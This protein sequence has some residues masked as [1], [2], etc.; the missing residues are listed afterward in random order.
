MPINKTLDEWWPRRW[1]FRYQRWI[2]RRIPPAREVA[3]GQRNLF[4]FLSSPGL[5]RLLLAVL[6]W[7][8]ATNYQNNL[9]MALCFL[10]LSVLL[11]AIHLTFANLNGL[12]VRFVSAEP[13]F[14]GEQ[15]QCRFELVAT[16]SRQQ[17]SLDW[18]GSPA[19][20][21]SLQAGVPAY[22][23]VPCT[24][25][26]RGVFQ[27]GRVRLQSDF[28]L[29]LIR[30][31]TWLD[32]C[33][34]V[35]VYPA[36]VQADFRDYA[37]GEGDDSGRM[38]AGTEDYFALRSYQPGDPLSRVAWK[39]FAAGRGVFVQEYVDYRGA[40]IWLDYAVMPHADPEMRLSKLCFCVLQL[41]ESGRLFGVSLPQQRFAPAA[42]HEHVQRVLRA[43]AVC[44]V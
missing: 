13:V 1:Q 37:Q 22:V 40:D 30:C 32:L 31:W 34:E 4:I 2:D 42:G 20:R 28:P 23:D 3:L 5:G 15:A 11:V 25:L 26:R 19:V 10:L 39:Q 14:A 38:V 8:G 6:L 21:V 27:P 9:A 24:A 16:S 35:V 33:C 18:P 41:G 12:R 7:V 29:G 17:L 36:P 44:P 43:L